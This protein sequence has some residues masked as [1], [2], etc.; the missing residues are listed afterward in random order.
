MILRDRVAR[1]ATVTWDRAARAAAVLLAATVLATTPGC[2]SSP[3]TA[4]R[5][6]Q[7]IAPT[8]ANLYVLEESLRGRRVSVESLRPKADCTKGGPTTPDRGPGE[9][10]VCYVTWFKP[11]PDVA[12]V[13]SYSVHVQTNGCYTADGEGPADLNGQKTL[14]TADGHTVT[15]PLW[16]FDGCFDIT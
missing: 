3:I 13:A 11:G 1:A 2:A 16:A 14:T 15:N 4:Q 7:A 5:L 9:D 6:E 12:V 8:F 10:W